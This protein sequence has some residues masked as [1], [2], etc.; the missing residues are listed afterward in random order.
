MDSSAGRR[1]EKRQQQHHRVMTTKETRESSRMMR[2]TIA[3]V[4]VRRPNSLRDHENL[5]QAQVSGLS[6]IT[7]HYHPLAR[8]HGASS[9]TPT[10]K[11]CNQNRAQVIKGTSGG[12]G[13]DAAHAPGRR[14]PMTRLSTDGLRIMWPQTYD[15]GRSKRAQWLRDR[16]T[17]QTPKT[18]QKHHSQNAHPLSDQ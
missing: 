13:G 18:I 2:A 6:V 5:H 10:N 3:L 1:S 15:R 9:L 12:G 4:R 8:S 11:R 16:L 14:A 7:N 17:P